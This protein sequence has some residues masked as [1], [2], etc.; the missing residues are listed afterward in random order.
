M[1]SDRERLIPHDIAYML[2]FSKMIQINLFTKHRLTDLEN[3]FMVT[4]WD[5][6]GGDIDWELETDK[7][8]LLY[9]K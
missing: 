8:T 5:R 9:L 2:N 3:E 4:S 6:S 1:K 7:C